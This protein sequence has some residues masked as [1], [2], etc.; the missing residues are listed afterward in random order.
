VVPLDALDGAVGGWTTRQA[1]RAL[2]AG[3]V[4]NFVEWFDFAIYSASVPVIATLFF[5]KSDPTAALLATFA[6]Y[7]VAFLARPLGGL[8]WGNLGDRIGRRSVLAAVVVVMGAATTC[9]GLLP[10]YASIG[11]LAPVLLALLRLVQGFSGGG[12]FTGSTSFI[13][14]FAPPGRRG[15]FAAISATFTTLP[16]ICGSLTVLAARTGMSEHAYGSW[17]WRIPFL[18]AG[19][20][21]VVGLA[22]RLRMDESPAF[23]ELERERHVER[24]PAREAIRSH[25]RSILLVFGIASLSGLG[26]YTLGA[27]FVTYL[28]VTVGLHPTT[29]LLANA[30]AFGVTVPLVPLVGLLGDRIGRKP[31]LFGGCAGFIALSVP[32]YLLAGSG[33]LGRAIAGQLM[34]AIPWMFVVSAV[35]VTQVEIFPTAVRYSGASIGYNLAYMAFGG[36]APLVATALVAH[37]GSHIAPAFYLVAVALLVLPAVWKLP[38][39]SRLALRR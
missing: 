2:A 38:E 31:L 5:P 7:G 13:T 24:A 33:G 16:S 39:T 25:G 18:I 28:T 11:V 30:A 22:I 14:E 3:S 15:L 8:F 29:A 12:E 21:A 34:V 17:G 36:T 32:G 20:L 1:L 4:G 6:L 23:A 19:P 35:V 9:I 27:Y 26:A 10:T 37:T